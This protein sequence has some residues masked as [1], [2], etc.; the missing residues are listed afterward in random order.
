MASTSS[1]SPAHGLRHPHLYTQIQTTLTKLNTDM[2][3]CTLELPSISRPELQRITTQMS[4]LTHDFVEL[5]TY[6]NHRPFYIDF[7]DSTSVI[8]Q[9][10]SIVRQLTSLLDKILV[11]K[12]GHREPIFWTLISTCCRILITWPG[13]DTNWP[14]EHLCSHKLLL[15]LHAWLVRMHRSASSRH[16]LLPAFTDKGEQIEVVLLVIMR[17]ASLMSDPSVLASISSICSMT[18]DT[19]G[20]DVRTFVTHGNALDSL[21]RSRYTQGQV[22][23]SL[24]QL[25]RRGFL[26]TDIGDELE[27]YKLVVV[28]A[29]ANLSP[30]NLEASAYEI[31]QLEGRVQPASPEDPRSRTSDYL[32]VQAWVG[33]GQRKHSDAALCMQSVCRIFTRMTETFTPDVRGCI[34][35]SLK[36]R[37]LRLCYAPWCSAL[38]FAHLVRTV[39]YWDDM[40]QLT[41]FL[42]LGGTVLRSDMFLRRTV[43]GQGRDFAADSAEVASTVLFAQA[44]THVLT[45]FPVHVRRL[46]NLAGTLLRFVN[47]M[48]EVSHTAAELNGAFTTSVLHSRRRIMHGVQLII[49]T[50][51]AVEYGSRLHQLI[52]IL[53]LCEQKLTSILPSFRLGQA[54]HSLTLPDSLRIPKR[55]DMVLA[56]QSFTFKF[57]GRMLP[58]CNNFGCSAIRDDYEPLT[59]TQLC[60]GCR[61]ATYC[62]A[63]CQHEAWVKGR[64]RDVCGRWREKGTESARPQRTRPW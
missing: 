3:A 63:E 53:T 58:G 43:R 37:I 51:S 28:C 50:S 56:W 14:S 60:S 62:C 21:R 55:L 61:R 38:Y 48:V 18:L 8:Y 41:P 59:V 52:A 7:P 42:S 54:L 17:M 44:R 23:A 15:A 1:P 29:F 10:Q 47:I 5:M 13:R 11:T 39:L 33:C 19:V 12:L 9:H 24:S 26:R 32:L 31:F 45:H 16:R 34:D 35:L 49:N 25:L 20:F 27:A 6:T 30:Q 57:D 4:D 46:I 22:L 2:H 40:S 36:R 64:H